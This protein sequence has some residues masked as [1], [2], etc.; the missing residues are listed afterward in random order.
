MRVAVG[1][2]PL[3]STE[4]T[5]VKKLL[6]YRI[7]KEHLLYIIGLPKTVASVELLAT[8]KFCGQF[9][10][11]ERIVINHNPKKDSL[12]STKTY[13]SQ[14]AVYVHYKSSFDVAIAIKCLNGLRVGQ[15]V[16]K[17][18]FGTSK[19]CANFLSNA[20]CEAL[21]DGKCPFI[22]YLERRRDLVIQDDFEFKKFIQD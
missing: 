19:Y 22:H 13:G 15:F 2:Q 11:L 20:K 14:V 16:L 18:S 7:I 9:G 17:C 10:S 3:R 6:E 8:S 4:K 21:R 12:V 1:Q 5:K